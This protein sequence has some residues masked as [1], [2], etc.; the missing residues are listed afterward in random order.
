[1]KKL[2]ALFLMVAT[3]LYSATLKSIK[4]DGLVHLSNE[5]A[6]EMVDMSI[7]DTLDMEKIDKAVKTLYKQNY[8]KDVWV[9]DAGEG[10]LVFHVKEKSVIAK[11]EFSG[12]SDSDKE[13]IAG[14]AGVKKG[15]IYDADKSDSGKTKI[16][17]FF[18]D[19]G[20]FDTVV[21]ASTTD[22]NDKSLALEYLINRGE[23]IIINDVSLCGAKK[24][25]YSDVEP[26]IANKSEE[27]FSWMW[28]FND[29]K[30]RLTD[31]EYDSHRIR[32][33]YMQ[34]GY[35]DAKVSAPFLKT[36]LDSYKAQLTYNV[37][38]GEQYVVGAIEIDIPE[39]MIDVAKT[40]EE[41]NLQSGKVFNIS[42]LRKD[43]NIIETKVADL[44]Y[45]FVKITPDIKNDSAKHI[46]NI[47]YKVIP[48]EKV[49]INNVRIAGNSRTIDRIIRREVFLA[50]GDLYKR[51]DIIDSKSSLKR[52][53]YFEDVEIKEERIGQN[54]VDIVVTVEEAS[55][56]AISGGVGYGS[57]DGLLLNASIA[58]SNIFGSG[59]RASIDAER[60]DKELSGAISLSNPRVF[61]S[62]YSLGGRIYQTNYDYYDYEEKNKGFNVFTG[63]KL[64]RTLKANLGYILETSRL[65]DLSSTIDPSLYRT[66]ETIKSSIVPGVSYDSTDDFYLPRQGIRASVSSEFA[67]IGGDEEFLSNIARFNTYYGLNDLIDYDLIIRYK[68]QARYVLDNG[69]LPISEKVYMGGVKSIRGYDSS[70][71]SPKNSSGALLGGTMMFANSIE[72]S[73]PLLQRLKMRGTVF[74]DYGMIGEDDLSIKRGGTGVALEWI[75]PLG[76]IGLIF[77]KP[78][79]KESND[80]TSS[81]EFTIGQQF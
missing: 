66:D 31:L 27:M 51:T 41:M 80:R 17:K 43:I 20:Y 24:L 4:F 78:L 34:N 70:S 10:N 8:F 12:I 61:D 68:A 46:A 58:D 76:P 1:M 63:R 2:L 35:L 79:M 55:T 56:G 11:V 73:F 14:V 69:Y 16:I 30:L 25:K 45:A 54:S 71:I 36:Y 22:L 42:R 67:G 65:S 52:T 26:T 44:G 39:N 33:V 74:L 21:E 50:N 53:G 48:G 49:Y 19:K 7:G 47:T 40:I 75:S 13:D 62:A 77:A 59:M 72:A 18:E 57:S 81:F 64:T 3:S 29:G 28:G 32:D 60:S 5:V 9:E 15:E 37:Q 6:R 23:N 38:E